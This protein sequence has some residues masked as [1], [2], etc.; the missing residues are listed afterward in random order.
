MGEPPNKEVASWKISNQAFILFGRVHP[1]LRIHPIG[2]SIQ[3]L[4]PLPTKKEGVRKGLRKN[5]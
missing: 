3:N 2:T 1:G 5:S 4:K